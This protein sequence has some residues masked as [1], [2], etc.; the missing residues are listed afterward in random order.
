MLFI[1][2]KI[3]R[4]ITGLTL[5]CQYQELTRSSAVGESGFRL[6]MADGGK[7]KLG[8]SLRQ[9]FVATSEQISLPRR[10]ATKAGA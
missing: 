2:G 6:M 10:S 9:G 3:T 8:I 5:I 7:A 4:R 1:G